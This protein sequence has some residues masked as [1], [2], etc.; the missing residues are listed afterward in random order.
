MSTRVLELLE[1]VRSGGH[2]VW[3]GGP[4]ND[5]AVR[6]IEAAVGC[7]LPASYVWFLRVYGGIAIGDN[8]ISGVID[9]DNT[10]EGGGSVLFELSNFRAHEDFPTSFLP[11]RPHEDGAYCIDFNRRDAD[12]ECPIVNYEYGRVEHEKPVARTFEEF[13]CEWFLEPYA[14]ESA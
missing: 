11:V 2:D 12:G 13:L 8:Y 4:A 9:G 3:V 5:S 1:R 6:E 14:E 10:S 7:P